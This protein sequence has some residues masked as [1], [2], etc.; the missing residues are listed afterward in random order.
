MAGFSDFPVLMEHR[1]LLP[2]NNLAD[3][4]ESR[5]LF[6]LRELSFRGPKYSILSRP[7]TTSCALLCQAAYH[8]DRE[9]DVTQSDGDTSR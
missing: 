2:L 6:V 3:A 1:W 5:L 7:H 9:S 8:I 4:T